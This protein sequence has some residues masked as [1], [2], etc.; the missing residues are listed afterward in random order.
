MNYLYPYS[1]LQSLV[2]PKSDTFFKSIDPRRSFFAGGGHPLRVPILRYFGR[3]FQSRRWY[4][5]IP[6][7]VRG[8]C[9]SG[10]PRAVLDSAVGENRTH[11]LLITSPAL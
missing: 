1:S 11:D 5:I 9:V 6:L 4:Q 8:A 2:H 10:L 7:G 3:P